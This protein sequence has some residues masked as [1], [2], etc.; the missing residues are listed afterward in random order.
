MSKGISVELKQAEKIRKYLSENNLVR[1]DLKIRKDDRFIYF[2]V[3][4]ITRELNSYKIIERNFEEIKTEP[5]SYKEILL[6]PEEL[7]H[8][9]PT[10]YD[11]I[12]DIILIKLKG[13]LLDYK[14]EIG[15]TLLKTNRNIKTVCLTKPVTGELRTRDLEVIAGEKCTKTIYKE[16]GLKFEVD[17]SK[18][19]FSP[20]LATERKRVA[21]LVKPDEIVVD[22]FAGIAPFSI[23]IAKYAHPKIVYSIDKNKNAI[24][25]AKKNIKKNNVLD[26]IEVI[27]ADAKNIYTILDQIG[28]KADRIIMN[29]PFSSYL[30]FKYALKIIANSCKI[31]YYD[32]LKEEK[33]NRRINDLKKIA[34]KNETSLINFDIRKIKT[35]APREFYIGIDITAKRNMP[36]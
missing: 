18:T 29:L 6:I 8:E 16:Y 34:E 35:Y 22:M 27:H 14:K 23:M 11:T 21:D 7:I 31:H 12:G 36:M 9:L 1:K 13:E 30:F 2:P 4:K 19:Y 33:V 24:E 26:K 25:Y 5:K 10:S 32:I 3:E 28:V 17:V 15:E 20:R